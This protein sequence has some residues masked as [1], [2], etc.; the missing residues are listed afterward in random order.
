MGGAGKNGNRTTSSDL[1][2]A[3]TTS[4]AYCYDTADRLT[5][6]TVTNPQPGAA[7]VGA[8]NLSTT[9][10]GASLA[11]D[12]HG[13][14][15][16]FA[17]Q[18]LGYDV[19]DQHISTLTDGDLITY[20]R[21]ASGNVVQRTLD[22]AGPGANEV[23]RFSS[24]MIL[25]ASKAMV[26]LTVS[27]PGGASM[28]LGTGGVAAAQWSYPNIHGDI[29]LMADGTGVRVGAR[30]AYDPFGQPIDPTTG[31]VGTL[32]ADNAVPDTLPGDAD[33]AWVGANSKLYEH[34]GNVA[35]IEMGARQYV[36]ALGR[37]LEVDPV[38]GG[39]TNAYDYPSDPVNVF[40]LSGLASKVGMAKAKPRGGRNGPYYGQ[41]VKVP[42]TLFDPHGSLTVYIN[43]SR[44]VRVDVTT[45]SANPMNY[46]TWSISTTGGGTVSGASAAVAGKSTRIVGPSAGAVD[47][48]NCTN[49]CGF[50]C[51]SLT[52]INVEAS[53]GATQNLEGNILPLFPVIEGGNTAV[54]VEVYYWLFHSDASKPYATTQ[55]PF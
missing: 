34:Q 49:S 32:T 52:I 39:V 14:T 55:S 20:L 36:A 50:A 29:I 22:P 48:R 33:Y 10:P 46:F 25:N 45:G 16:S 31:R 53:A 30:Y 6:T 47:E 9:G 21:D 8:L 37:F 5:G 26:Q 19:A 38:E 27:L 11:Y 3:V 17:G 18:T 13:N 51:Q 42:Q 24:G 4:T 7:P 43:R 44:E 40:D 23:T 35:T 12:A 1:F 41:W 15:T 2:E 28:I 54:R